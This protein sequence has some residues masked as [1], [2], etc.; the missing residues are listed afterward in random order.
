MTGGPSPYFNHCFYKKQDQE[1]IE[2]TQSAGRKQKQEV[3]TEPEDF[4]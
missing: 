2:S 3:L 1:H 4:G